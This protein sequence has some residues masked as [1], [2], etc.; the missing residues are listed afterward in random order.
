MTTVNR[1]LDGGRSIVDGQG[2]MQQ[3]FRSEV[4]ELIR[5]LPIVGAGT[6][7]GVV[8]ASQ[9]SLYINS[10]GSTGTIQYRKMLPNIGGDTTKGWVAV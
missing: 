8:D 2:M 5:F 6:P 3:A 9:Y 7:E 1:V 4:N 10:A